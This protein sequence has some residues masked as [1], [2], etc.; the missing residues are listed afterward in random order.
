MSCRKILF[1]TLNWGLGHATRC[2]PII[3]HLL[4]KGHEVFLASDGASGL[5][6]KQEFPEIPYLSLPS[7]TIRYPQKTFYH[8]WIREAVRL[9]GI[10]AEERNMIRKWVLQNHFDLIISDN[11]Y[12][13][14]HHRTQNIIITHQLS[15]ALPVVAATI[16]NQTIR[17]LLNRFD[18]C[19]IPD[20]EGTDNLSGKLST[21]AL[22][23]EKYFIGPLSRF[24]K[25]ECHKKYDLGIILSGPEPHRSVFQRQ[26]E[27]YFKQSPLRLYWV[28]GLPGKGKQ[29]TNHTPC[30]NH[31]SSQKLNEIVNQ[32]E[33]VISRAGYSSIMDYYQLSQ[34][35]ILVPTPNQPEQQYLARRH[36]DRSLIFVPRQDLKDLMSGREKLIFTQHSAVNV[37]QM[38]IP[39]L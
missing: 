36:K 14:Y 5:L 38:Q 30:Y 23:I 39:Q 6:L 4:D 7:Y 13:A 19:W 31:L 20:F 21:G 24:T 9:N 12:G 2:I 22:K 33:I 1:A 37:Q 35:A 16:V 32:T 10:I 26:L 27:E 11:R 17:S 28:Y 3:Q 29:Q 15:F 8:F 25:Q 34:K 18:Q